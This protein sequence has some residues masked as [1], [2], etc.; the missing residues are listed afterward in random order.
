[1]QA[2]T[3][4]D[5][6]RSWAGIASLGAGLV[7]LALAR[8]HAGTSWG[9]FTVLL[10]AATYQLG[11]ALAVL[12]RN[13]LALRRTTVVVN[14]ALVA[15][16]VAQP[17]GGAFAPLLPLLVVALVIAVTTGRTSA[18]RRSAGG[19]VAALAAGALL[20]ASITTP[21]L[22]ATDAGEHAR[23]HGGSHALPR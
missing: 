11:W 23:P 3:V 4:R 19:H 1:M 15:A 17:S 12:A 20:V 7:S 16:W 2:Y 8:E 14:G 5:V 10:V 22:A 9:S 6:A 13:D 21:A 18:V